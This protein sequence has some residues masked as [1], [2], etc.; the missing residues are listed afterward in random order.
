MKLICVFNF[1]YAKSRF[2]HDAA[3]LFLFVYVQFPFMI[4]AAPNPIYIYMYYTYNIPRCYF[5]FAMQSL[6]SF[7]AGIGALMIN[8]QFNS[9]IIFHFRGILI[10]SLI[11]ATE[12]HIKETLQIY[13]FISEVFLAIINFGNKN[14]HPGQ[15]KYCLPIMIYYK[16]RAISRG[17]DEFAIGLRIDSPNHRKLSRNVRMV[18]QSP[19]MHRELVAN[20]S[21][22]F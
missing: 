18:S 22:K 10:K 6:C 15:F 4:W 12:S 9:F 14:R 3:H 2:S 16:A 17:C 1:A 8:V 19:R 21:P 7:V 5:S 11:T 20:G 13:I